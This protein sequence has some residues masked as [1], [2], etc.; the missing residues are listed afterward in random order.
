MSNVFIKF[1]NVVH[2]SNKG[3]QT[4]QIS[5]NSKFQDK[6]SKTLCGCR[7]ILICRLRGLKLLGQNLGQNKRSQI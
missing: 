1:L 2:F 4:D 7:K 3:K 5:F 6:L